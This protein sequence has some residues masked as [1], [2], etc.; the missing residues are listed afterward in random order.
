MA[1]GRAPTEGH[2][3]VAP[4][5]RGGFGPNYLDKL[6]DS[7]PGA[8]WAES[9]MAQVADDAGSR[10]RF[11]GDGYG[12]PGR[13]PQRGQR[14]SVERLGWLHSAKRTGIPRPR[15]D[16]VPRR[17][18][19]E[20]GIGYVAAEVGPPPQAAQERNMWFGM[21]AEVVTQRDTCGRGSQQR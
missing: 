6:L 18:T 16:R 21:T 9:F 8:A 13:V 4:S 10:R 14:E 20:A 17:Q 19:P 3:A 15:D 2:P 5:V 12:S 1:A 7:L 11:R